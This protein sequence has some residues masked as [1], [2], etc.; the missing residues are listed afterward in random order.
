PDRR[1]RD[2]VIA[3]ADA[4]RS[5]GGDRGDYGSRRGGLGDGCRC[6]GAHCPLHRL[7]KVRPMV[8]V[9][10]RRWTQVARALLALAL[11]ALVYGIA[12]ELGRRWLPHRVWLGTHY[13]DDLELLPPFSSLADEMTFLVRSGI[14]FSSIAVSS[15]RVLLG[16]LFGSAIGIL[17]GLATGRV[18]RLEYLVDPW[19]S[20]LRFTPAL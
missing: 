8:A 9:G 17:L 19:V 14:L 13:I 5:G 7:A 1:R 6:A 2:L 20:F 4:G 12:A 18:A 10:Q 15:G 3:Y 16:F 11:C